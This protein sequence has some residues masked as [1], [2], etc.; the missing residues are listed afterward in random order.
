MKQFKQYF[1]FI[2][3]SDHKNHEIYSD[4]PLMFLDVFFH[5]SI[6]TKQSIN[7]FV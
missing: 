3:I 2:D 7:I 4:N 6:T 5:H 1:G